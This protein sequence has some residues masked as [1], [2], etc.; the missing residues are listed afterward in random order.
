MQVQRAQIV[1]F[2]N[3]YSPLVFLCFTKLSFGAIHLILLNNI[4][5]V[6]KVRHSHSRKLGICRNNREESK[7]HLLF[8]QPGKL[9]AKI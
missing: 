3:N 2:V 8:Y 1:S 7:T 4:F 6:M 9:I 5:L